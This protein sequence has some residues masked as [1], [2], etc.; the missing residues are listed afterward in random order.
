VK[1]ENNKA[2]QWKAK[3][4][5]FYGLLI[6]IQFL[7]RLPA[8]K[9]LNPD[10]DEF[11]ACAPWFP[12]VGLIVGGLTA[13]LTALLLSLS[14]APGIVAIVAVFFGVLLTGAFH[15]DGLADTA[16]GFGGGW[17]KEEILRIMRDSRIGSYGAVSLV[18]LFALRFGALWGMNPAAW[19]AAFIMAH[20]L[21]RWSILPLM[22]TQPYAR[23]DQPGLGKPIVERITSL[24]FMAGTVFTTLICVILGGWVGVKCLIAVTMVLFA[25]GRFFRKRIDGMTGDCLGAVNVTC[26]VVVL[27]IIALSHPA[28][29]SPWIVQ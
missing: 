5:P 22:K 17:T 21:S 9:D 8:P 27:L 6:A 28:A 12:V 25:A 10:K 7:T 3:A 4:G 24:G 23:A 14:L 2:N 1:E 16:D 20:V 11:G 13:L 18:A 19:P 29:Q 15:E 26:E